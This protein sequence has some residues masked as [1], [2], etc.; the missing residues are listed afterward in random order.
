MPAHLPQELNPAQLVNS[1]NRALT[2]Q[3]HTCM[4]K[5]NLKLF[6]N[7]GY[8]AG[9]SLW[10]VALWYFGGLP[11]LR[12]PFIISSAA[13]RALLR[14]FGAKVGCDVVIKPG[15]RVKYPWR[16]RIGDRSW[17]GEDCWIDNIALVDI[18][19]DVCVSQGAFLCT[20]NHDWSDPAFALTAQPIVLRAGSWVA[21]KAV[22]GPGV[23]LEEG[24]I[25]GLGS[26]V[27][28]SVP[29]SQVVGGNPAIAVSHRN[30]R[31]RSASQTYSQNGAHIS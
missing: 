27:T 24:A 14:M 7:S 22:V 12:S 16:L 10:I 25:V 28:S 1:K 31:V 19:S 23:T 21:A 30:L 20:G 13:R 6:D 4:N 3:N 18:R 8:S 26:V 17:I 11:L 9:R 15:V 29:A 5:V 2:R